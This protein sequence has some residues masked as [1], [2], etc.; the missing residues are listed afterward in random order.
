MLTDSGGVTKE[1]FSWVPG[2]ILDTQTEWMETVE[3]VGKI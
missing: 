2:I 1:A 3:K